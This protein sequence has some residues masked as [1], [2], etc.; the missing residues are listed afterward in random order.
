MSKLDQVVSGP[1][2]HGKKTR[3][4]HNT[5]ELS[6]SKPLEIIHADL[7]GPTRNPTLQGERYFSL[8]VDEYTRMMWYTA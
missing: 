3:T 2:Q 4:N 1:C 7:C 5:K 6:T 8:F